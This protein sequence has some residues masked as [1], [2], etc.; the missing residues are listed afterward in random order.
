MRFDVTLCLL[1]KL[2]FILY[3]F[4]ATKKNISGHNRQTIIQYFEVDDFWLIYLKQGTPRD[5][6]K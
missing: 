3:E 1:K 4:E 2:T 5:K 6:L